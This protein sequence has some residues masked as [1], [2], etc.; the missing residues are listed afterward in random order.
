MENSSTIG[1]TATFEIPRI[2]TIASDNSPHKVTIGL[3][4]LSPSFEYVTVPKLN[5]MAYTKAKV[6]NASDYSMLAG[7]ANGNLNKSLL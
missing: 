5:P 6:I 1:S 3:I 7:Q 2:A 4:N